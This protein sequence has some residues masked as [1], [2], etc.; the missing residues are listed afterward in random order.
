MPERGQA[1]AGRRTALR[2]LALNTSLGFAVVFAA[3][4]AGEPLL[5]L[6]YGA[7][8]VDHALLMLV[9][10]AIAATFL[11]SMLSFSIVSTRR[12]RV[13]LAV[14]LVVFAGACALSLWLIPG[15][16]V[17]GAGWALFGTALLRV[18]LTG[19]AFLRLVR[20]GGA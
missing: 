10:G 11:A 6:I 9:A 12:F 16:G 15:G 8:Y 5:R 7:G 3:W 13:N 2:L 19:L 18:V 1:R 14:D 17:T 4:V 20:G